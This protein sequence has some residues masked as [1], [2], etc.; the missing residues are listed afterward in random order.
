V[1]SKRKIYKKY[2]YWEEHE[3]IG[4]PLYSSVYQ[5]VVRGYFGRK[6]LVKMV[7]DTKR[8]KNTPIYVCATTAFVA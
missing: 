8:M 7:S 6:S 2:M 3:S 5:T 4:T 1:F